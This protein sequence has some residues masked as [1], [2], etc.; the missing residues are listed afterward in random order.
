[1]TRKKPLSLGHLEAIRRVRKALPLPSRA[2][3][4]EKKYHRTAA[5]REVRKAVEQDAKEE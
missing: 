2:K 5:R 4:D 1:M 3:E